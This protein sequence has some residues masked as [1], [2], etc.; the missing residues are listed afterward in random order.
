LCRRIHFWIRLPTT[1]SAD[2]FSN[3]LSIRKSAS[4]KEGA[5]EVENGSKGLRQYR[6]V[7]ERPN[8]DHKA[9]DR[10]VISSFQVQGDFRQWEHLLWIHE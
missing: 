9:I 1:V 3:N 4:E 7:C 5:F 8:K 10:E 6:L 2:A